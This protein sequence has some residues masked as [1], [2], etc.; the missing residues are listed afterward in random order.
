MGA[1]LEVT[2]AGVR[3]VTA[4][5]G[6]DVLNVDSFLDPPSFSSNDAVDSVRPLIGLKVAPLETLLPR[7]GLVKTGVVLPTAGGEVESKREASTR[8]RE[9][10]VVTLGVVANLLGMGGAP[11]AEFEV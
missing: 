8:D 5:F 7:V 9:T 11:L 2:G 6:Y 3:E 1:G 10:G 4:I